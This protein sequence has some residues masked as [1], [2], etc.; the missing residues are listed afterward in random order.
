MTRGPRATVWIVNPLVHKRF[1]TKV[2]ELATARAK[3]RETILQKVE[4]Q[5]KLRANDV[6]F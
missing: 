5:R 4:Q 2:S 3:G 6:V 1:K